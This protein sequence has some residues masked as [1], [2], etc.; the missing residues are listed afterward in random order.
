[1]LRIQNI[2]VSI[3]SKAIL[4]DVSFDVAEGEMVALCGPNG[5]RRDAERPLHRLEV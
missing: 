4:T 1:M 2:S 3:H 5:R